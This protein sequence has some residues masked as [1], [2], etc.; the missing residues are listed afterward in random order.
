LE[1]IVSIAVQP[2]PFREGIDKKLARYALAGSALLGIPAVA[3]A[4]QLDIYY[5]GLLNI[6]VTSDYTVNLPTPGGPASFTLSNNGSDTLSVSGSGV[7]FVDDLSNQP[8]AMNFGD[9][10]TTANAVGPGGVLS[11]Y[12]FVSKTYSGN[13]PGPGTAYLGL[14]FTP[15]SQTYT[16]WAQIFTDA[17]NSNMTLVDY[18]YNLAPNAD[19]TAGATPEPSSVALFALGAAGILALRKKRRSVT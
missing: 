12:S 15:T 8:L 18:A 16:G 5:S 14:A 6:P 9:L 13:W 2:R 10:I 3:N 19:I 4:N 11:S 17:A 7:T 1:G